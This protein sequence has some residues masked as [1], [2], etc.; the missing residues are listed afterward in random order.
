VSVPTRVTNDEAFREGIATIMDVV[1]PGTEAL[2][3]GTAVEG[4]VDLL[5][6]VMT[7]DPR[8]TPILRR[9]SE[10]G[11]AGFNDLSELQAHFE[12]A[13]LERLIFA[14]H[15]AYYMSGEVRQALRYPGQGRYPV[16]LATPDQLCS[17]EL[18]APVIS[19]G[20]IY[21]PTP[22]EGSAAGER[23]V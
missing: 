17:E 12:E 2:P 10:V 13:E 19:R 21:V 22:E 8:L 4:H 9:A 1:L 16:A 7:A 5:D 18:I 11:I 23:A 3:A 6:R 20:A 14:L 15:A